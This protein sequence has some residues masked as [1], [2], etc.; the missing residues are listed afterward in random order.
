MSYRWT[1]HNLVQLEKLCVTQIS[2]VQFKEVSLYKTITIQLH[3]IINYSTEQIIT[4][5]T[6]QLYNN[7]AI[8]RYNYIKW[9]RM[10]LK[11]AILKALYIR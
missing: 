6:I 8:K 11:H 5:T 4:I 10:K 7:R 3:C 9:K 2:G 1:I